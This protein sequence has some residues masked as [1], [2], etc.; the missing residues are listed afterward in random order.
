MIIMHLHYPSLAACQEILFPIIRTEMVALEPAP[1]Y[2]E[3]QRG[4]QQIDSIFQLMQ[5]DVYYPDFFAKAAYLFCSII[6]GH[7][8][9]NG[10]KRL[11]VSALTYFLV[12]NA[13]CISAPSMHAV[14]DALREQFV[15]LRWEENVQAFRHSHEYFFYHLALV[16]ADRAQK[17]KM[18]FRQE[19]SAVVQLLQFITA[20]PSGIA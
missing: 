18:T 14:R 17:G 4:L 2:A 12:V 16:I 9:S 8:F 7:P 19:Q 11:A 1:A 6:D 15:N 13:R 10:N 3:E 20:G 5:R